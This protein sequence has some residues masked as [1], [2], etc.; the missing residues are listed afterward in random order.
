MA[1]AG[2]Q[3]NAGAQHRLGFM[4]ALGRGVARDYAQAH[5]WW[6]LAARQGNKAATN[7]RNK[8]ASKVTPSQ[9][10]EAEKFAREWKP[11]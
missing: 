10:A 9:I 7:A 8:L 5:L 1:E 4:Y 6:S 11:K 2:E 3:G